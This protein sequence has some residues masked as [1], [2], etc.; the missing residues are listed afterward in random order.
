[1]SV[2][3]EA[4]KPT[5]R[6]EKQEPR[7][8]LP[9][10]VDLASVS[11]IV[12][13]PVARPEAPPLSAMDKIAA[14]GEPAKPAT[15]V[16]KPQA[17]PGVPATLPESVLFHLVQPYEMES[18]THLV[19]PVS[20]AVAS[21]TTGCALGMIPLVRSALDA[22]QDLSKVSN[23]GMLWYLIYAMVFALS[24]GISIIAWINT[25]YGRRDARRLMVQIR[26]RPKVPLS[27]LV[28]R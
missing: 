23:A 4:E 16:E 22:V 13:K 17:W 24:S 8:W 6:V 25:F 3:I 1:M 19:R 15:V 14:S 5:T 2:D 7:A 18:L 11:T 26:Q 12:E 9:N 21:L 27:Q 10:R 20:L 28:Q